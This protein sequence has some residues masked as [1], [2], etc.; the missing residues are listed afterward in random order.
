MNKIKI[1]DVVVVGCGFGGIHMLYNLREMGFD[2]LAFEAG[3]DVGGAWYWNRYP[4]ARC[5][6]ESLVYSYSFSPV[7]DAEWRWSERYSAQPEIQRY[8]GFVCDRLDLRKDIR[9]Q[10][11]V[12]SAEFDET[13]GIWTLKTQGGETYRAR[14]LISAAGPISAP[15]WPDI[16][17]REKFKGELYHSARWPRDK[18]PDFTGKRVAVIGTGSSGTQIIPLVAEQAASL[19]VM[20]RTPNLHMRALN[21]PLTEEDYAR[22]EEIR[23]MMR[24]RMRTFEVV[25]SGDLFMEED[26]FEIRSQPGAQLTPEHRRN[27]LERRMLHGGATVPR[28]FSDVF[29]NWEV[30]AQVTEFLLE[31]IT[32]IVEDPKTA[33][34]LTPRDV[35]YGTKRITVGTDYYE[36][37]NRDNVEAIDVKATPIERFT[38]KGLVVGGEELEFD[39][40]I[41]AS[42]FDAVTGALTTIDIR[43]ENGRTIEEAWQNDSDT[44]LGFGVAGFPNLLMIGGPGSPSVLVNV[45]LSNEYQVEWISGLMKYM[46]RNGF[47]R[48]DVEVD[49]QERWSEVVRD[50]IRGTVMEKAKSWYVGANVPGKSR[51]ILAY[52]GGIDKYIQVCEEVAENGYSGLSFSG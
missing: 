17:E 48:F 8:L 37:Y 22:W 13:L 45:V 52:A 31:Q 44:Y 47:T 32:E 51:G 10:S 43:G 40:I 46:R 38:E 26:L 2:V 30:N 1:L 25:G 27:V 28:A 5:D 42:G 41:C 23:D 12:I 36:T 3:T 29:T 7:I 6:A 49:A 14:F 33:E 4:G 15:I 9:F 24:R 11:R 35:P 16:P 34:I 39:A 50:A 18:E 21:R 19:S 20:V